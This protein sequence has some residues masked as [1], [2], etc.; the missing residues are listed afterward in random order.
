VVR[1]AFT[2]VELIFAIVIISFSVLSLPLMNQV[3]NKTIDNN[4]NQ[5]AIFA[6]SSEMNE[7]MSAFW[8]E[9]SLEPGGLSSI[10]RVID[11][12]LCDDNSSSPRFRKMPG[13]INQTMHRRCLD[14]NATTTQ[15]DDGA[16]TTT[17]VID[18]NNMTHAS[19]N[20]FIDTTTSASGYKKRYNS[21]VTIVRPVVF[22]ESNSTNNNIKQLTL[23]VTDN[24][25]PANTIT[26]F[27]AYSSNIG[28]ID[29]FSRD[30]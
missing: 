10:A 4:I 14:A 21:I 19:A 3:M 30:Y 2:L 12:G 18:L 1:D 13:H 5:E 11:F 9:N 24:A 23:E 28:E 15:P 7:I 25:N 27:R 29:Y 17:V 26:L 22:G 6:A 20:V 8:D 16:D